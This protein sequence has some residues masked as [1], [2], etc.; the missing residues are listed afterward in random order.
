M[1]QTQAP[2]LQASGK[3]SRASTS[4]RVAR[5]IEA[6]YILDAVRR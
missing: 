1:T 5:A 4:T 2:P 6:A 3:D